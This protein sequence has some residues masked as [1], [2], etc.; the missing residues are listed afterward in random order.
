MMDTMDAKP[1]L[2]DLD[3]NGLASVLSIP[4]SGSN[5]DCSLCSKTFPNS[6]LLQQ[7]QQTFHTDKAFVCEICG[8]AFRFR[9]NLA[10]HR[11]VHTALKPFVCKFCGKSSRLKG[12]LTKH[13]LK[14]HKKEQNEQI[15]IDD[16]IIK[17][18]APPQEVP[19]SLL[20]KAEN[21]SPENYEKAILLSFGF[22]QGTMDLTENGEENGVDSP[23]DTASMTDSAM[24][25]DLDSDMSAASPLPHNSTIGGA[26]SL[27]A[28]LASVCTSPP[29]QQRDK[30][31]SPPILANLIH[32]FAISSPSNSTKTEPNAKTQ[33]NECGKH[34]RKGSQLQIHLVLNH[35]Y[36]PLGNT[37][38]GEEKT[39][40]PERSSECEAPPI[41]HV[42]PIH[43]PTVGEVATLQNDVR[44]IKNALS[45]IKTQQA[46]PKQDQ[47]LSGLDTRVSRLEKQVE[48]A[49]NSIYT[50]VQLQTGIS[51]S[52]TKF[53]D[54]TGDQLRAIRALLSEGTPTN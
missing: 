17:K 52:L 3:L 45:E 13:I 48:M 4:A 40:E 21:E 7:H 10:E 35:G 36:P 27:H 31:Q 50:L 12:N 20:P 39:P 1:P 8:K 16:I 18:G 11:S 38:N 24:K 25:Q 42:L 43:Q 32:S 47:L 2:I 29:Q 26:A 14:H 34:F 37:N 49:L 6:K 53:R 54:E 30:T 41:A 15:G 23:E 28:L 19:V 5:H 22:D 9:S 46:T 51:S 33:C 44:T